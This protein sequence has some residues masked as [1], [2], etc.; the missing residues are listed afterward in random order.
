MRICRDALVPGG[1]CSLGNPMRAD[2]IAGRTWNLDTGNKTDPSSFP[3]PS[4]TLTN[5]TGALAVPEWPKQCAHD[6]TGWSN[7]FATASSPT[8][9]SE[10]GIDRSIVAASTFGPFI[11][12]WSTG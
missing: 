9:G 4:D 3:D 10:N 7:L 12:T 8:V 11:D 6:S 1:A 2:A 5:E